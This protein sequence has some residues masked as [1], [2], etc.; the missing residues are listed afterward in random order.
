VL[1][2]PITSRSS[3]ADGLYRY[4][5]VGRLQEAQMHRD[6]TPDIGKYMRLGPLGEA[7]LPRPRP[8]VLL[9]DEIDK[10]DFDLPNDLLHIFE[11]GEYEI[12]EL[13]RLDESTVNVRLSESDQAVPIVRGR[14]RCSEFPI[15]VMTSNGERE[16]PA[17]FLRRCVRLDIASPD[18]AAL[19]EIVERHLGENLTAEANAMIQAFFEETENLANDQLLN[20]VYLL[21]KGLLPDEWNDPSKRDALKKSLW[22]SLES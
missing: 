13:S 17:P 3:L 8:R 12:P 11:E 1:R 14:V 5:A 15:V 18:H 6:R 9:I 20:V 21:Q 7:L 16:F 10:S 2:W 22:R 19:V 4:D